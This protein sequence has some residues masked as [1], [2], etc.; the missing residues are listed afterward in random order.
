MTEKYSKMTFLTLAPRAAGSACWPY[1][2][3]PALRKWPG[4]AWSAV[5]DA[6]VRE[7]FP[8]IRLRSLWS[9][10]D[11]ASAHVLEMTPG[12][13][14]EGVDVHR[15]GPEEVFVVSGTFNDGVRDYPAGSFIHAPAGSWHIPQTVTGC[16]LFVFYPEG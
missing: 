3:H 13:R 5:A 11:G 1:D 12:S 16:V 2:R 8:G 7:L 14:W 6:P 10:P 9:G 15:P 4:Y